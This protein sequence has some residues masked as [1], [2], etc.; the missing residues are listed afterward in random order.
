M[1]L[2]AQTRLLRVLQQGEFVPVGG[3]SPVRTNV[4]IVAAT[5]RDLRADGR[6]RGCFGRTCSIG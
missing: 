3:H 6:A 1:P 2:E 5:H 4:R